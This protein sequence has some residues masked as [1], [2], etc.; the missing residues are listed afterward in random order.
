MVIETKCITI[1]N[2][3]Y[4]NQSNQVKTFLLFLNSVD[5]IRILFF[6]LH[7]PVVQTAE[8]VQ[9]QNDLQQQFSATVQQLQSQQVPAP[10]PLLLES[11]GSPSIMPSEFD[12]LIQLKS[13]GNNISENSSFSLSSF[14]DMTLP[15]TSSDAST[16]GTT[17]GGRSCLTTDK[18][19]SC[20]DNSLLSKYFLHLTPQL[21]IIHHPL[22]A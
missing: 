14:L 1:A 5:F 9:A 21:T 17:A 2:Q 20:D 18:F 15:S 8:Q 10:A 19:L 16:Q 12:D 4:I 13:S 3:S 7:L 11:P 22:S 6:S